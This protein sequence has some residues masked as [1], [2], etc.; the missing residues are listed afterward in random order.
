MPTDNHGNS[1]SYKSSGTN[2]QVRKESKCTKM[3]T[4]PKFE[5]GN[6][7]C[8]RDYG[9]GASNQNSYHY[10]NQYVGIRKT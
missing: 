4:D 2:S 3:T 10:S 1:Y 7:Y 8:A 9:P 5:Q 6:H